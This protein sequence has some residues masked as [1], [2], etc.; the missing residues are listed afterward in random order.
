MGA[1]F[2]ATSVEGGTFPVRV[3]GK[4]F[5]KGFG[6]P[7]IGVILEDVERGGRAA[8]AWPLKTEPSLPAQEGS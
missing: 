5:G 1:V 2:D 6:A 8:Y 7:V 4:L 3:V